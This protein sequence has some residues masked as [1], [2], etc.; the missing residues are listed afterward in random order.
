MAQ[1]YNVHPTTNF[2]VR[3]VVWKYDEVELQRMVLPIMVH[4][5]TPASG[6]NELLIQRRA[7]LFRIQEEHWTQENVTQQQTVSL[8]PH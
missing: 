1:V 5:R 7:P 6:D 2:L 8:F 3:D 4:Y